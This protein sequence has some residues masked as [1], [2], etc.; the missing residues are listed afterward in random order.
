MIT[1]R[2]FKDDFV[3]DLS[4]Y[5]GF[6]EARSLFFLTYEA[7]TKQ[8]KAKFL[9]ESEGPVPDEL[10]QAML[11]VKR[12][13]LNK[14]PIQ[15]ILEHAWFMGLKLYV[16]QNVLIP[17]P[18]TEELVD[19][20]VNKTT[21]AEKNPSILDIGTGSGCIPLAIKHFE[22]DW[23]VSAW[24]ISPE[25]LEVARLNSKEL[26]LDVDFVQQSILH[27]PPKRTWSVILS[28]PPYIP[29]N[30]K[31]K[32]SSHVSN[33]EPSLALFTPE[34][35]PLLFYR[36]IHNYALEC[37]KDGGYLFLEGHDDFM[38][39]VQSLF[40]SKNWETDLKNDLNNKPR[41]L[42]ARKFIS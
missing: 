42:R 17:R 16:N 6:E 5:W 41:M 29:V 2:T 22:K 23:L 15:Y 36:H 37:L 34:D 38:K 27:K 35:D 11:E 4:E 9:L 33:Q 3:A 13:L 28:N 30:L 8:N 39:D 20:L 10:K 26:N 7:L 40:S 21:I 24:D 12:K 32:L 31:D 1:W 14:E 18:E 25:A 19:W